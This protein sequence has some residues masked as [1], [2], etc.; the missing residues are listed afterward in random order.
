MQSNVVNW[1]RIVPFM[2]CMVTIPSLAYIINALMKRRRAKAEKEFL[3]YL[4]KRNSEF[5][6][7]KNK[8]RVNDKT[9]SL[10]SY[11]EYRKFRGLK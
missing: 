9:T 3:E 5:N 8:M 6:T 11:K 4:S 7:I 2:L 10:S 1:S